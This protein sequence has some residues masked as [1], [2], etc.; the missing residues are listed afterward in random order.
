MDIRYFLPMVGG[1]IDGYY[2]VEKVYFGTRGGNI[3][4]KLNF[5]TY[6]SL[7]EKWIPIYRSKIQ[8][9]ELIS[10]KQMVDL[11]E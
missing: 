4:L 7:G 10:N 5:S 6:I 1:D 3:C 2:K 8:P 11:Y 9:G